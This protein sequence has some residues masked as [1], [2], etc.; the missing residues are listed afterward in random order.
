ML[1]IASRLHAVR[2]LGFFSVVQHFSSI[3]YSSYFFALSPRLSILPDIRIRTGACWLLVQLY[4]TAY[5][6]R[7]FDP[8]II[9][10]ILTQ[11]K[12]STYCRGYPMRTSSAVYPYYIILIFYLVDTYHL[13]VSTV[14]PTG[15]EPAI[16]L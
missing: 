13:H 7:R 14:S 8:E 15:F 2:E 6:I 5:Y 1:L 9:C 11:C 10:F 4:F 16:P 3:I 12:K